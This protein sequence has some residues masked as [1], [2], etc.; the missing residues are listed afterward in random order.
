[1]EITTL[2]QLLWTEECVC[3]IMCHTLAH[4]VKFAA[5]TP[6]EGPEV[7]GGT[8]SGVLMNQ[9]ANWPITARTHLSWSKP[10]RGAELHRSLPWIQTL[11]PKQSSITA[12][13]KKQQTK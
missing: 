11:Q 5:G 9:E 7:H 4:Q 3:N 2:A 10:G 1:M 8:V 13:M 12:S 6:Q